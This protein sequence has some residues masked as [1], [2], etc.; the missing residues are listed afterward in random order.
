MADTGGRGGSR[1]GQRLGPGV[2]G[3]RGG[4]GVGAGGS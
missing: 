1:E 3:E 4:G 2:V